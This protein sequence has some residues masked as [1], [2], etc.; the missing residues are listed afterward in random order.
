MDNSVFGTCKCDNQNPI[1]K[2]HKKCPPSPVGDITV[3]VPVVINREDTQILVQV[4]VPFP[5]QFPATEIVQVIKRVKNLQ[6]FICRDKALISGTLDVNVIY[7][8]FEGN[9]NYRHC[10]KDPEATFGDVKQIGFD[11]PFSG[12]VDVPGARPNDDFIVNFA[13][14]EEDCEQDILEDPIR[15][16]PVTAFCKIRI[17]TIVK[18]DL[19]IVRN[20]LVPIRNID[21]DVTFEAINN[22]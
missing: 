20:V 7:K 17:N 11:V 14:V 18:V 2:K 9:Y 1:D 19:S 15:D 13:G 4:T 12:F 5:Q 10:D 16:C 8:T 21:Q 3:Q 22:N 6:I